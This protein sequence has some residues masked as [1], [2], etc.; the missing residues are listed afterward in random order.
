MLL[1][2]FAARSSV[3]QSRETGGPLARVEHA[4]LQL[5][6]LDDQLRLTRNLG[7]TVSPRGVPL[8]SLRAELRRQ[9]DV[10]RGLLVKL[11]RSGLDS[12]DAAAARFLSQEL[13][14]AGTE[15]APEEATSEPTDCADPFPE[16]LRHAGLDSLTGHTFACYGAAARRIIVGPDTLDR[17]SI[18]GLLG[19]TDDPER[20]RRL[21]R[22]AA[23]LAQRER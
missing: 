14:Q 23:G 10:V 9:R 16:R 13:L 18:L 12:S 11:P 22:A 5:R 1:G 20:R 17:L 3:A 2:L 19:R 15:S 7:A 6:T 21:F 8:D 4:W